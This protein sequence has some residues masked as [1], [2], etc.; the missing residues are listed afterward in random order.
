ME[1][2]KMN[3][4]IMS[5][6]FHPIWRSGRMNVFGYLESCRYRYGMRAADL[7]N[8]M[9]ESLDTEYLQKVKEEL[10]ERELALVNLAVDGAHIWDAD[11]NVQERHYQNA[12]AH[13]AAAETL[14]AQSVR[15][16]TGGTPAESTY[17]EEQMDLIVRRYREYAQ[18]AY[19]NGYRVGPENHWGAEMVPA[20]LQSVCEA[21]DHP[22]FGVLLH[23]DRWKGDDAAQGNALLAPWTMH[24]H[25]GRDSIMEGLQ[26]KLAILAQAGYSG[27]WSIE[28]PSNGYKD[29]ALLLEE[30]RAALA[31]H[32]PAS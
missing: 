1:M 32:R 10:A 31:D 20:S 22:A 9:L 2:P 24:T 17:T 4:A 3:V 29:A 5:Y 15:I 28:E 11:P 30:L 12:L 25:F 26:A 6:S 19:D 23:V 7:W 18:R 13:L 14:G 8:A 16:D 27:C 21:V